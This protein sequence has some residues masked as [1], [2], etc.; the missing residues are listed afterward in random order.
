MNFQ[1]ESVGCH[2][3]VSSGNSAP[4]VTFH[5][6]PKL[7]HETTKISKNQSTKSSDYLQQETVH[8]RKYKHLNQIAE[9]MLDLT[10]DLYSQHV[11]HIE[12]IQNKVTH[13]MKILNVFNLFHTEE[14]VNKLS[15]IGSKVHLKPATKN[16]VKNVILNNRFKSIHH[17][18][19][20]L[21]NKLKE[22]ESNMKSHMK[23]RNRLNKRSV[24]HMNELTEHLKLLRVNKLNLISEHNSNLKVN[25]WP[26]KSFSTTQIN[27][28][29]NLHRLM[30][31]ILQTDYNT[32]D[33]RTKRASDT[34]LAAL[35]RSKII[36]K[37][38]NGIVLNKFINGLFRNGKNTV[39]N[40]LFYL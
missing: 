40:G 12:G 28:Q 4:C 24:I 18:V 38:I 20:M 36:S 6:N 35:N 34:S 10:N 29:I 25:S 14:G 2:L 32:G 33:K 15:M 19:V 31:K 39:I 13:L 11:E 5:K 27:G 7:Q 9:A 37:T 23:F 22:F 17:F 3:N 30:V 21:S 1:P 26:V 16:I 8:E